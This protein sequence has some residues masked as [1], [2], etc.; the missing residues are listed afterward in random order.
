MHTVLYTYIASHV[1]PVHRA[2][3]GY[4]LASGAEDAVKLWDLRKLKVLK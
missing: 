2:E 4:Y 3:N 1:P